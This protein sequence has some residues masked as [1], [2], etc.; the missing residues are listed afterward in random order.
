VKG[1][2]ALG[3][4]SRR[5]K[6]L[7]AEPIANVLVDLLTEHDDAFLQEAVAE[8]VRPRDAPGLRHDGRL[9]VRIVLRKTLDQDDA[10]H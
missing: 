10:I 5:Q 2:V 6:Q 8:L 9:S 3:I 1:Y 4:L 7:S